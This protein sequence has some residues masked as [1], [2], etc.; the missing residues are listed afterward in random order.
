MGHLEISRKKCFGPRKDRLHTSDKHIPSGYVKIGI[1]NGH[2]WFD[3]PMK[4]GDVLQLCKRL[5]KGILQSYF[6]NGP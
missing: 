5:P 6:F 3:L 2:R 1:E 4:N